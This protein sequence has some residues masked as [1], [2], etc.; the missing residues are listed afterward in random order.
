MKLLSKTRTSPDTPIRRTSRIRVRCHWY[1]HDVCIRQQL[2][3]VPATSRHDRLRVC[4]ERDVSNEWQPQLATVWWERCVFRAMYKESRSRPP[5]IILTSSPALFR[6][7]K[8]RT[9]RLTRRVKRF[10]G[11]SKCIV[12]ETGY[13]R[14]TPAGYPL[15]RNDVGGSPICDEVVVKISC[16]KSALLLLSR[17]RIG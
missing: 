13:A 10:L 14:D 15:I 5:P 2:A 7:R 6:S 3:L 11:V 4:P 1:S 8:N 16:E 12:I 17:E 9:Y